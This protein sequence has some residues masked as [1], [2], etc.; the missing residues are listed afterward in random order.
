MRAARPDNVLTYMVFAEQR[1]LAMVAE[2]QNIP[3]YALTDGDALAHGQV[4][5]E[6]FIGYK[7]VL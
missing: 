6:L 7:S 1:L 4:N 5:A 3:L 2:Q